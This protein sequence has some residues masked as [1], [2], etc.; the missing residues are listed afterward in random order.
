MSDLFRSLSYVL[1]YAQYLY[2]PNQLPIYS[3]LL[4]R[5]IIDL[6]VCE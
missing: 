6:D 1:L 4:R 3:G 2:Q 5:P